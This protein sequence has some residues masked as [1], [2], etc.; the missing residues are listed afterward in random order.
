VTESSSVEKGEKN[1]ERNAGVPIFIVNRWGEEGRVVGPCARAGRKKKGA[2][3][4]EERAYDN[5][6]GGG[7][8]LVK[9]AARGG[10]QV[11]PGFLQRDRKTR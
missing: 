8:S 6:K 3:G 4:M 10:K 9:L 2:G 1:K 7:R 5:A 11:P